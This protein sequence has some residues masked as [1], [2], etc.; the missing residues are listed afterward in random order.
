MQLPCDCVCGSGEA[1][2]DKLCTATWVSM[3]ACGASSRGR[4]K[5]G[6]ER[7]NCAS[8]C[9]GSRGQDIDGTQADQPYSRKLSQCCVTLHTT[10]RE[11]GGC[12]HWGSQVGL[13]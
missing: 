2:G 5:C 6:P 11:A 3:T 13:A 7:E 12:W 1:A 8:D 4:N 9:F 10:N